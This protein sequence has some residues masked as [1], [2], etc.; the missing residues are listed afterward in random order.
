MENLSFHPRIIFTFLDD[1]AA[2]F[3]S[4]QL[5]SIELAWDATWIACLTCDPRHEIA[6]RIALVTVV[7]ELDRLS[8]DCSP[9]WTVDQAVLVSA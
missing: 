4:A 3:S 5:Q 7:M 1:L 9:E 6:A 8:A 2:S